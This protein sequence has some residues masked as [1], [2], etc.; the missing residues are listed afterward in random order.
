MKYLCLAYGSGN[1]WKELSEQE[2][3]SL[4]AQDE[5]LLKRGDFVTAVE[6]SVTTVTNWEGQLNTNDEPFAKSDAPMAGFYIIEAA[7]LDEAIELIANTPC[8]RARG[9]VEIRPLSPQSPTK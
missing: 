3:Q 4:L 1:D 6:P 5:V 8:A 2:Q 9:A 7:N